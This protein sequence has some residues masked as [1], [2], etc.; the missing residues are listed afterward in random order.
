MISDSNSGGEADGKF[1]GGVVIDNGAITGIGV[2]GSE[3]GDSSV[4]SDDDDG[5]V[6]DRR[7]GTSSVD[8]DGYDGDADGNGDGDGGR[9]SGTAGT[10][11]VALSALLR[12]AASHL[13]L[14]YRRILSMMRW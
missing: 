3:D 5:G 4:G 6:A 11:Y 8:D 12:Q 9:G 13:A 10:R 2:N 7:G 14:R 1:D